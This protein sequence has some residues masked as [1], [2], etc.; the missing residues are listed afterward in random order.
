MPER[1]PKPKEKLCVTSE[2]KVSYKYFTDDTRLLVPDL[3][4]SLITQTR[5]RGAQTGVEWRRRKEGRRCDLDFGL[6][7]GVLGGREGSRVGK[8]STEGDDSG[9]RVRGGR[10]QTE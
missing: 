10:G 2:V 9:R 8:R 7:V 6:E 1:N 3:L 5:I 4:P